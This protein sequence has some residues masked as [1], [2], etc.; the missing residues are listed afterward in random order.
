MVDVQS[1]DE[2]HRIPDGEVKGVFRRATRDDSCGTNQARLVV[3]S[4]TQLCAVG[5]CGGNAHEDGV[6]REK[7]PSR[8]KN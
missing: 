4:L 5:N 7:I 3:Y 1:C 6:E 8:V 2:N